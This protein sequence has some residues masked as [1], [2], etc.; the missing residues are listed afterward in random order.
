MPTSVRILLLTLLPLVGW[1]IMYRITWMQN[2]GQFIQWQ[3]IPGLPDKATQ[4]VALDEANIW[5]ETQSGGVYKYDYQSPSTCNGNCWRLSSLP[6]ETQTIIVDPPYCGVLP[7]R[8]S[9]VDLKTVC[10]FDSGASKR[11]VY[12][13]DADGAVYSWEQIHGEYDAMAL[14][15]YPCYGSFFGLIVAVIFI[16]IAKT[17]W[18]TSTPSAPTA[19]SDKVISA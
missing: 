13:V 5:V 9:S 16:L 6:A 2:E 4:I 1:L 12:S 18:P 3:P 10:V 11:L 14:I 7:S 19:E 15:L 17:L 8:D